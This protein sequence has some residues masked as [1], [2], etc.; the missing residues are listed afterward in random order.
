MVLKLPLA[1]WACLPFYLIGGWTCTQW[2]LEL[3]GHRSAWIA[4]ALWAFSPEF[5]GHGALM[6]ADAHASSLALFASHQLWR[7]QHSHR[8][9]NA[10]VA[11][12]SIG[13]AAL[14]KSTLI[15]LY[16]AAA[17][18]LLLHRGRNRPRWFSIATVFLV[19]LY[20][21]NAGY[22]FKGSL[23]PIGD[24]TFTSS[25]LKGNASNSLGNRF[26]GAFF[27]NLPVPLP[28]DF[29]LG[30][31]TQ[32]HDFER[33]I[34]SYM[35]GT[36]SDH[37]WISFYAYALLVKSP[38]GNLALLLLAVLSFLRAPRPRPEG[39]L[40]VFP[41][42]LFAT[43]SLHTGFS[44]HSRYVMP[45]LPFMFVFS[46]RLLRD[47]VVNCRLAVAVGLLVAWSSCSSLAV[48]PHSLSYFN[49]FAGG[50][51]GGYHHLVD[52]NIAWGQDLL[53]LRDWQKSHPNAAPLHLVS[54][55]LVDPR[56]AGIDSEL[57]I[58]PK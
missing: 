44:L 27:G 38:V 29:I 45:V 53:F 52:S 37:G 54:F 1:R 6:T 40:I 26:S 10:I 2:S 14:S 15:L 7:W 36:W 21:I 20:V 13:L 3:Y 23:T 8:R 55:G 33:G 49:E 39:L 57:G 43:A 31:D 48:F 56:L 11:G 17:A 47:G 50:P 25:T 46:S 34:R 32:K 16:P 41:F 12:I 58:A 30:I 22:G 9:G 24:Y 51:G 42:I 28:R 19:G 4:A 5:L 35:H 18:C